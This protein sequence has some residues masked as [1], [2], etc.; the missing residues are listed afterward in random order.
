MPADDNETNAFWR[1]WRAEKK[2]VRNRRDPQVRERLGRYVEAGKI[3][4][5]QELGPYGLRLAHDGNVVDFWPRTTRWRM[6]DGSRD[7]Y[8]FVSMLK[9]LGVRR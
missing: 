8:G 1:S 6:K 2:N 9:A 4:V 7:G 3:E 5:V